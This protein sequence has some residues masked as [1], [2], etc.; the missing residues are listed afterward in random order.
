MKQKRQAGILLAL[1]LIAAVVWLSN[2]RGKP[3]VTADAGPS[4]QDDP[5]FNVDNP[6]IRMDEIQRARKTEYK[7]S[8]RNPFSPVQTPLAPKPHPDKKP[9]I[10]GPQQPPPTPPPPPLTLPANVKCFGF[11]VVPNGTS[12]RAFFT[13]GDEVYVVAEGEVFL[14]RYRIL[15]IGNVNLEFEEISSGRTGTAP[16]EEQPAG[17]S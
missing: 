4:L 6:H 13:D 7:S 5:V 14:K 11:G 10:V 8:G 15:R 12:R 2:F 3:V 17:P 9:D 1:V 16:I